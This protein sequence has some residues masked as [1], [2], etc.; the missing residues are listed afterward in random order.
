VKR[1]ALAVLLPLAATPGLAQETS[2][3]TDGVAAAVLEFYNHPATTRVR[4]PTRIA[5]STTVDGRLASLGG[6]L[7]VAGVVLGDVVVINGDLRLVPGG[8]I[9]GSVRV[10]GGRIEGPTALVE[11]SVA[12]HPEALRFR[13]EGDRL[14]LERPGLRMPG[15]ATAFGRLDLVAR[16]DGS[17]NR[18]EGLPVAAGPRLTLGRS[19]PTV[20]QALAVY[21]TRSGLRIHHGEFGHDIR[22]EQYLGGHRAV[23]AGAGLHR[24]VDPIERA[25][26]SDT[27]NSLATFVLHQDQRD[28]YGRH[29]W[30]AYVRFIGATL[31]YDARIEYRDETH[32]EADV[33]SPWSLLKNDSPWRAQP[34]VAGGTLRSLHGSFRWDTRNDRIDP[35]TGWLIS[36]GVEQGLS[37]TLALFDRPA[38]SEFTAVSA[39]VRRYVRLGPHSRAAARLVAAGAPDRGPLPPQ[40]QRALGGEGSLPG[41]PAFH[42]DCGA[43]AGGPN[44]GGLYPY[45]GCDRS[46][47]L[48]AELRYAPL[49]DLG[50]GRRFE[51][52]FDL[53]AA[54]EFVLFANAGRAWTE[55]RSL[56]GRAD[57]GP[58]TLQPDAGIGVRFGPVGA[59]LAI[60]LGGGDGR[61][62]FFIRLGPRF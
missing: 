53:F 13:R 49:A 48:Q 20:L 3:M 29:G 5:A 47:L 55:A 24:V 59:Y 43:R 16:L 38:D 7:V 31:P 57:A 35:A 6:P 21:Q 1:L 12:A 41:Y 42:F 22:L 36:I 2:P 25:G 17:Y 37:G 62:N 10:V 45:Y 28:H 58:A 19:N 60:P 39:D 33:A 50:I 4:G 18:V 54:P 15:V 61:T 34:R 11:G 30:S 46:L 14:V 51:L 56:D 44:D 27:E 23:L 9:S 8:R 32:R 40:R 26:L 52:D